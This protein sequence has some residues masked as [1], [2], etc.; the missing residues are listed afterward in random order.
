MQARRKSILRDQVSRFGFPSS[1]DA[2]D[3]TS[4]LPYAG[5]G[6][7]SI[8]GM[9]LLSLQLAL[10][11]FSAD[12][13]TTNRLQLR[14]MHRRHRHT[15]AC[16]WTLK[17]DEAVRFNNVY[18]GTQRNIIYLHIHTPRAPD[19]SA[20]TVAKAYRQT[21]YWNMEHVRHCGNVYFIIIVIIIII[22]VTIITIV[23]IIM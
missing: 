10:Q 5:G 8:D 17:Y 2:T 16:P 7:M 23:I 22:I 21:K 18:I 6:V 1:V 4:S 12:T 13:T 15:V 9:L 3:L 14:T 20:A 11:S 19:L